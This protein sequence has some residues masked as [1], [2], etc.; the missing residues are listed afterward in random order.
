MALTLTK[1]PEV[2]SLSKDPMVFEFQ[3]DNMVVSAG[4][5]A[6]NKITFTSGV[7]V[8]DVIV[9]SW[10]GQ[11]L[12]MV[13]KA[14]PVL[15]NE[16]LAGTSDLNVLLPYF[17]D[18][19][20][21]EKDFVVSI[22]SGKIDLTA[23]AAGTKY[24]IDD[25]TF[26]GGTITTT[27]AGVD[28]VVRKNFGVYFEVWVQKEDGSEA[29]IKIHDD[30][31]PVDRAT[32][33]GDVDISQVLHSELSEDLPWEFTANA[34]LCVKSKR[35]Y[36]IRY[37]EVFGEK[38][39]VQRLVLGSTKH[40]V[41]GGSSLIGRKT[42]V[43]LLQG[44]SA[45]A[46][47]CMRIGDTTRY[48][49]PTEEQYL[50]FL[51][52]RANAAA[53]LQATITYSD[54]S[55]EV[56]YGL[57][58]GVD[59]YGKVYFRAS[60]AVFEPNAT[61]TVVQYVVKVVD[62]DNG[63]AALSKNYTYVIDYSVR[64][65]VRNFFYVNSLGAVD[66]FA[67]FG[68]GSREIEY[69]KDSAEKAVTDLGIEAQ[70]EDYNIEGREF[71]EAATGFRS[72]RELAYMR[73]FFLSSRKYVKNLGKWLPIIL[74]TKRV[75][76]AEDGQN[77][78][79][80]KFEYSLAYKDDSLSDSDLSEIIGY[81]LP[82]QGFLGGGNVTINLVEP[83]GITIDA[84]PT[85]GSSNAVSSNGV[86]VALATKQDLIAVGTELQYIRGDGTLGTLG[87]EVSV[88]GG[89]VF[90][91]KWTAKN[92]GA[93]LSLGYGSGNIAIGN[94]DNDSLTKIL[95]RFGI[96]NLAG[97]LG[98]FSVGNLTANTT[99][100]LPN[101]G[102]GGVVNINDWNFLVNRPANLVSL[103]GLSGGGFA[104][105]L[106][107]GTWQLDATV[108]AT[109]ANL[110]SNYQ[111]KLL[112][113]GYV[114][115]VGGAVTYVDKE[116]VDM[117]TAQDGIAGAKKFTTS[118]QVPTAKFG[119]D[120]VN[121]TLLNAF[122]NTT[123]VAS[124]GALSM[125][126]ANGDF[127]WSR[128][129]ELGMMRLASSGLRVG[130]SN[131]ASFMLDVVG[132]AGFTGLISFGRPSVGIAMN[133]GTVGQFV[134]RSQ[135]LNGFGTY[136]DVN[137]WANILVADISGFAAGVLATPLT[138]LGAGTNTAITASDTILTMAANLQAQI[139][140]KAT[141][142]GTVNYLPKFTSSTT[143]GN[144]VVFD[145]G[146][147]VGVGTDTPDVFSRFYSG[148]I[149]GI[150]SSGQTSL[151]INAA[152]GSAV[153]VDLGVNG[154]RM[155]NIYSDA[156]SSDISVLNNTYLTF[157]SGGQ[158]RAKLTNDG[159]FGIG[160]ANPQQLLH[161]LGVSP[162]RLERTGVGYFENTITVVNTGSNAD[163]AFDVGQASS[164]F[165]F[166]T[167]NS[168]NSEVQ[169]LSITRDGRIGVKNVSPLHDL[170]VNGTGRF[171]GPVQFDSIPSCAVTATS[172]NHLVNL[173]TVQNLVS[174]GFSVS[175]VCK[176]AFDT[177]Q[178]LSGAKTQGGY[179]TQTGDS[180]LLTKQNT[181]HQN[182]V[183]VFDGINWTRNTANDTDAEIRG[184]GHLIT[185][186]TFANSQWVNS[187][188]SSISIGSTAITYVQWF[189]GETDPTVPAYAKTLTSLSYLLNE[190][191]S[192][193]GA[194]SGL[195]SQFL[196]GYNFDTY[197]RKTEDATIT[198]NWTFSG[199]VTVAV[200]SAAGNPTRKDYVDA[201]L[202]MKVNING[203]AYGAAWTI[204]STDANNVGLIRG[205]LTQAVLR[206][207]GIG[208][209]RRIAVGRASGFGNTSWDG[210][211]V[212]GGNV[213]I[214]GN[215]SA[216]QS[217]Y[218]L[219]MVAHTT[220]DNANNGT[221][222][223][224]IKFG[225]YSAFEFVDR[226]VRG[227]EYSRADNSIVIAA[228]SAIGDTSTTGPT[229]ASSFYFSSTGQLAIGQA[230]YESKK[231]L[232]NGNAR[233]KGE[234]DLTGRL[235]LN[236]NYGVDHNFVK[237]NG[238]TVE[239]AVLNTG[240]LEDG[241]DIV[242]YA[243]MDSERGIPFYSD[244]EK[245]IVD[246]QISVNADAGIAL[247]IYG[248]KFIDDD[249]SNVKQFGLQLSRKDG[250]LYHYT[251]EGTQER[252]LTTADTLNS[253]N[254]SF[255]GG[256]IADDV[257]FGSTK[258]F[259]WGAGRNT[260]VSEYGGRLVWGVN[261]NSQVFVGGQPGVMMESRQNLYLGATD[262]VVLKGNKIILNGIELDMAKVASIIGK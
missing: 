71:F 218:D 48:I 188:T 219:N 196:G 130:D 182:G 206:S 47:A 106:A 150:T 262:D 66:A 172:A 108:Y 258:G 247:G 93:N 37:A 103:A 199:S 18:N 168:S 141:L 142:S 253:G 213:V 56:K 189:A 45:S 3:T 34:G 205:S 163:L 67:T 68:K 240:E 215:N 243:T 146:T 26:V 140:A 74:A 221:R 72:R 239:W 143:I 190:I 236:G 70:E 90:E 20:T 255:N 8:D 119:T 84:V 33:K 101:N 220:M 51:A 58:Y 4:T 170:D 65:S 234:L 181:A 164:G 149:L 96:Q 166:R 113:S 29:V 226:Y 5:A 248:N 94:F 139:A 123:R 36:Y 38:V 46:D 107:D 79:G 198:G 115:M 135:I 59:R 187:N 12:R 203:N 41:M 249:T 245:T 180:I 78:N 175:T 133:S 151:G 49:L 147:N 259:Y 2:I 21:I 156:T 157:S 75:K 178:S 9:I 114:K 159:K 241:A 86:A 11:E 63:N 136:S 124:T 167:R 117:S 88:L 257:F 250:K 13:A 232:V 69:Y 200:A 208:D 40:V 76:E 152:T 95:G 134:R 148:R 105:R 104:K 102:V 260:T 53:V 118:I 137:N 129:G 35:K 212:F 62:A 50:F 252:V 222:K 127:S 214:G 197:P 162:I 184:K 195:D 224:R 98:Q 89:S 43:G 15:S 153:Y 31:I 242:K 229:A 202:A 185:H 23:R 6:V 81:P 211:A 121:L 237:Y 244:T 77:L 173:S 87:S 145:N 223:S 169:S 165:I 122:G 161:L 235:S 125:F 216:I 52:T 92:T 158:V 132:T 228:Y 227:I 171:V 25:T 231:F 16:F 61:K 64:K 186:G 120:S 192:V 54:A 209:I 82:P 111:S 154:V 225:Y 42:V 28:A 246:G 39:Q 19:Y 73:D 17:R 24:N 194:A 131:T 7:A 238:S 14:V 179:T 126:S 112:G 91:D 144:S 174:A 85:L 10:A 230:D 80:Y 22:V 30:V 177:D 201:G 176:L 183:Y 44:A 1:E 99:F 207:D 100:V 217:S 256:Y 191:K 97:F 57:S 204:G 55:T 193:D 83:A 210:V 60:L 128:N 261:L 27:V 116:F 254:G 251:L 109:E 233:I 160:T 138:G 155:F 110:N 32:S